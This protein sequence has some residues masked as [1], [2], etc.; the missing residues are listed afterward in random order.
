MGRGNGLDDAPCPIGRS[1]VGDDDFVPILRVVLI[2]DGV[3]ARP[4]VALLVED[5]E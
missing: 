5:R 1:P 3:E 4:D 2:E